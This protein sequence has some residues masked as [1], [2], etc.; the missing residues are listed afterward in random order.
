MSMPFEFSREVPMKNPWLAG[1]G[2]QLAWSFFRGSAAAAWRCRGWRGNGCETAPKWDPLPERGTRLM[3]QKEFRSGWGPDRR[4]WG[5]WRTAGSG[6]GC[7]ALVRFWTGVP[8]RCWVTTLSRCRCWA[9]TLSRCLKNGPSSSV[10]IS[11]TSPFPLFG[12][13]ESHNQTVHQWLLGQTQ[14][15]FRVGPKRRIL[16][17]MHL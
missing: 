1:V 4:R 6:R 5:P 17:L 2:D 16:N 12:I 11:P 10:H 8:L 7:N 9:T 14:N 3:S 15:L 13:A